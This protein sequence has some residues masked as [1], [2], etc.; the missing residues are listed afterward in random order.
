MTQQ[1]EFTNADRARRA[2]AAL[3]NYNGDNDPVTNAEDFLTDLQ[4]FYHLAHAQDDTHPTFDEAL[5]AARGHF[6]AEQS[7]AA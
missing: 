6:E 4:H 7:E 2:E 5:E 1:P 3:E